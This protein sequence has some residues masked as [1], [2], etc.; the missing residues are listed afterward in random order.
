MKDV[1][2]EAGNATTNLTKRETLLD[3]LDKAI[4][5]FEREVG[6]QWSLALEGKEILA[7]STQG[8][9]ALEDQLTA[10]LRGERW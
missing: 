3:N 10:R 7:F 1:N 5:N 9:S 8:G 6:G 4:T 2:E